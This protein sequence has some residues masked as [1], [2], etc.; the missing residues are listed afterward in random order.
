[1]R[2]ITLLQEALATFPSSGKLRWCCGFYNNA[3]P[4]PCRTCKDWNFF[5]PEFARRRTRAS[6]RSWG[7]LPHA[8][9]LSFEFNQSQQPSQRLRERGSRA[10]RP[11]AQN[12]GINTNNIRYI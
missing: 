9:E 2:V 6:F 7:A 8:S 4:A 11:E 10:P 12:S 5:D 3:T 1:M